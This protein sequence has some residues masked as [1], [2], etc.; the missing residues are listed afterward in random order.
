MPIDERILKPLQQLRTQ[1]RSYIFR[2]GL[3]LAALVVV[4]WFLVGLVADYGLFLAT[5]FDWVTD[6]PRGVRVLPFLVIGLCLLV[7]LGYFVFYRL[8][9]P[10]SDVSLALVLEKRFPKELD[11]RLI[12]AIELAD[13]ERARGQGY[14]VMMIEETIEEAKKRVETLPL[15]QVFNYRRLAVLRLMAIGGLLAGLLTLL[16]VCVAR[17]LPGSA[18]AGGYET[19]HTVSIWVER[20]VL[21]QNSPWPRSTYL[22]VVE[23]TATELRIGKDAS[24]PSVRVRA[25]EW[26]VAD[27]SE[28]TGWRAMTWAEAAS[29]TNLSLPKSLPST[30]GPGPEV[31][32]ETMTT[33]QVAAQFGTDLE[34]LKEAFERLQV[35]AENPANRRSL[36]KLA[37]PD[38]VSLSYYGILKTGD[39]TAQ[40]N[41]GTRGELRLNREP[42]GDFTTDVQGLKESIAYTIR[43]RDF[44]TATREIVLVP[45]P[46]LTKLS[47]IEK[48]PAYLY[49][50]PTTDAGWGPK[51]LQVLATK[52]FSL[53]GERSIATVPSGTEIEIVGVADKP[54]VRV[55][56]QPKKGK[57]PG[58]KLPT[59]TVTI[60]P[61]GEKFTLRFV[62]VDRLTERLEFDLVMIDGD[63]VQAR[64]PILIQVIE[65][66]PPQV[67]VGVDILRKQ[68]NLYLCTPRA[69]VPFVKESII[70]DDN[71]LAKVEYQFSAA[72][73]EATTVIGLQVQSLLTQFGSAPGVPSL[74]SAFGPVASFQLTKS[75]SSGELQQSAAM[76]VGPFERA[77]DALP[78]STF[79]TLQTKLAVAHPNTDSP[80]VVKE[81]KFSLEGDAFDLELAD[82]LFEAQGK[83]MR[84]GELSAEIQPRFRMELNITATDTNI[85]SGP[86]VGRNLEPIRL[87]IISEADLLA[88]ITKDEEGIMQKFD[89][90]IRRLR[91]AQVKLIQQ[92]ERLQSASLP[93]EILLAARVRA[94]D[95]SQD[96]AKARDLEQFVVNE[97][98]RLRR[99]VETNRCNEAVPKRYQN[100]IIGP[101]EQVLV[102]EQKA[103]EDGMAQVREPLLE[104]RRPEDSAMLTAKQ[105]LQALIARLERI[106]RELGDSIS[107]GKLRDDLQRIIKNQQQVSQTFTEIVKRS[108]EMLFAPELKALKPI[109]MSASESKKITQEI[110]WK[111]FDKGELKLRLTYPPGGEISGPMEI[112]VKDDKND[113]EYTLKAGTKP[114]AYQVK[115]TPS[116]GPTVEVTVNVK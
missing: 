92:T 60:T 89:E 12:T 34:S 88:E 59:D 53:T 108:R 81:I 80:A 46:M 79:A 74:A 62:D 55:E 56:L 77:F 104:G 57:L 45:P 18:V 109:D 54:L 7:I 30:T 11:E 21:L 93:N 25:A 91:E 19:W 87:L 37:T 36:R 85:L 94:E 115:L 76:M 116:V 65:D 23:P 29:L 33:D 52:E 102:I 110:D 1:L 48:Q 106:R 24:A 71:G 20:N 68:G 51:L 75:L 3:L 83:R 8:S 9:R 26:V 67:E 111:L 66:Q 61:E 39:K 90:A 69:R 97:Y 14:S 44:R 40:N 13:V 16:G 73:L 78:K 98:G 72:R 31:S 47:R 112:T 70:R 50:P 27:A 17:N 38:A 99:E 5:N 43:A 82:N 22:T 95:I 49:H 105:N 107:E 10:I 113:F 64:R 32:L 28:P 2:E 84:I 42:N 41:S 96:I 63:G 6:A 101:L 103:A 114:G 4:G 100:V 58:A 86:K 15:R 35:L